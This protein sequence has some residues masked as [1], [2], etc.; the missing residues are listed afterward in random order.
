MS[1]MNATQVLNREFLD[2]RCRLLDVAASLDRI[3]QADGAASAAADP[4][5]TR[6]RQAMRALDDGQGDRARRMQMIF[7]LDYDENWLR[8]HR[9]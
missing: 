2:V 7:S 5:M 4:R 8:Q 6:L 9:G 1:S 3:D